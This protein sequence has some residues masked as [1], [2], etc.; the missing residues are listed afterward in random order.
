MSY[1]TWHDYGY[2]ICVDDV[3][4]TADRVFE[5]VHLAPNFEKEFY[6]WIESLREEGDPECISELIT[7]DDIHEFEDGYYCIRGLGVIMKA[8]IEE[9][10]DIKLLVCDDFNCN[11]YLIFPMRYPWYMSEKEKNMTEK[12]IYDLFNKYVSILTDE[13]ISVDYQEVENGG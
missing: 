9:C 10:E 11:Y 7:M 8:V 3:K 1:S 5:F 13:F 2:G 12:D 6:K 4:T